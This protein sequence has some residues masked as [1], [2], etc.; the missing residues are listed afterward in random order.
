MKENLHKKKAKHSRKHKLECERLKIE[1]KI[2]NVLGLKIRELQCQS[3]DLQSNA[4]GRSREDKAS[5]GVDTWFEERSNKRNKMTCVSV[6]RG[7]MPSQFGNED[8]T[9]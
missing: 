4:F 8:M 9:D 7:H 1:P 5:R 6:L 2:K 3:L